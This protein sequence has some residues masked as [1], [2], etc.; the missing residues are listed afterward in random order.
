MNDMTQEQQHQ[1]PQR[2]AIDNAER[3]IQMVKYA[4]EELKQ[5]RDEGD[6]Q[7]LQQATAKLTTAQ[8]MARDAQK[9]LLDQDNDHQHQQLLQTEQSLHQA[10]QDVDIAIAAA[11]QPK[12]VR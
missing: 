8:H 9:Q 12:Q 6:P 5:A 11:E 10:L 3:A 7:K 4:E 1:M 2:H